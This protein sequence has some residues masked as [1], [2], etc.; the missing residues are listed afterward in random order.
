MRRAIA[1]RLAEREPVVIVEQPISLVRN[2]V[3]LRLRDRVRNVDKKGRSCYYR[4]L[5]FPEK[6]P[7]MGKIFK[8]LNEDLIQ[9]EIDKLL[10]S[11]MDR[12]VCYDS[13]TQYR[14]VKKFRER[15]SVYLAVDDRTLTV[16]GYP[17]S[18]EA[19]AESRLLGKVDRVICV[20]EQLAQTLKSRAPKGTNPSIMVLPNAYNE[21]IFDPHKDYQAPTPLRNIPRARILISG[22]VSERIDWDGIAVA[23]RLRPE[24]T[25]VFLGPADNGM[26]EKIKDLLGNQG[27]YHPAVP[28]NEVPA[29][30]FHCD[31]CAVAY[32]LNPF[33]QASHPLKAIEY[34]AIGAPVISTRIP[35]LEKYAGAIEWVSVGEGKSY[36]SAMDKNICDLGNSEVR[37]IRQRAVAEDSWEVRL[38]QFK[39]IVNNDAL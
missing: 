18:G 5:H 10:P 22:H 32:R 28:A 19:E 25:W 4:P 31:A 7:G 35:S 17:I 33:T 6:L 16:W 2:Q 24:W 14:L 39:E 12:I 34:L 15:L 13:P 38:D 26:R 8:A 27:F 23:S 1:D 20:S 37:T 11:Q 21:R 3:Y 30:I 36:V 9:R 29:W